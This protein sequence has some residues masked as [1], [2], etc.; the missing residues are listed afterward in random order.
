MVNNPKATNQPLT[1]QASQSPSLVQIPKDDAS[2]QEWQTF[3]TNIGRPQTFDE[4]HIAPS[5]ESFYDQSLLQFFKQAAH[6]AGL[7]PKQASILHDEMVGALRQK[8]NVYRQSTDQQKANIIQQ[9]KSKWGPDYNKNI[10][11]AQ[12]GAKYFG[13]PE[14]IMQLLESQMGGEHVL[15]GLKRIGSLISEDTTLMEVYPNPNSISASDAKQKR[16]ALTRDENFLKE[17]FDKMHPNHQA[18]VD[19]LDK[20]NQ[21]ISS[22]K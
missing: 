14:Q 16:A 8:M 3:F 20:L 11:D 21:I 17:L 6:K 4:Y 13:L 19:E 7:T 9:L 2:D 18:A 12:K 15:E 5:Q 10:Y 22:E 1:A